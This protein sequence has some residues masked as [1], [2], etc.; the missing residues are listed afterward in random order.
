LDGSTLDKPLAPHVQPPYYAAIIAAEAIGNSGSTA[1][2]EL[3][4]N[5]SR[6]A[7]YA[8][9]ESGSLVRA[10]FINSQAYLT[11]DESRGSVH[12]DL[13]FGGSGSPP[14]NMSV[15]RLAIG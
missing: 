6:I 1:A 10:V 15:K 14:L 4:V 7:G 3:S 5:N 13:K 12:I 8:F 2:V 9:Y 11:G